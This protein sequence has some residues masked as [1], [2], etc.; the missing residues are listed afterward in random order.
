MM[1]LAALTLSGC[2][3]VPA[4][5]APKADAPVQEVTEPAPEGTEPAPLDSDAPAEGAA[6][7]ADETSPAAPP[8]RPKAAPG[9][10]GRTV[11]A[12]G[13]PAQPGMWMETPLITREQPGIV[14]YGAATA[15]VTLIPSGGAATSGSRLS[16]AAMRALGAP[17]TDLVDLEVRQ[18]G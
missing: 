11:A 16:L 6:A 8:A 17:L 4:I 9:L 13:D 18:P 5:F 1:F 7:G 2:G 14:A 12:L 10:P 15:R 3:S